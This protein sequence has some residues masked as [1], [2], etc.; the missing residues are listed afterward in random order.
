MDKLFKISLVGSILG[1]FL[2]L[3]LANTLT[4]KQTNI[5]DINKKLLNK[6]VRV[7]GT[8]FNIRNYDYFQVISIRDETGKIDITLD[9]N[10]ELTNIKEITVTG[11]VKEYEQYLQIQADKIMKN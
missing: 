6:K 4:L 9:K 7:Q 5:V 2:I 11:K 10:L 1:I 8:I 3:F